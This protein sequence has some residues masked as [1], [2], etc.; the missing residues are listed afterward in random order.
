M[1]PEQTEFADKYHGKIVRPLVTGPNALPE[2]DY[3]VTA[4][5]FKWEDDLTI[6]AMIALDYTPENAHWFTFKIPPNDLDEVLN[7]IEII[8]PATAEETDDILFPLDVLSK[9]ELDDNGL[10]KFMEK[11]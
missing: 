10:E 9:E 5:L 4:A 8:R 3:F 6:L 11:L 2:K 1:T 7:R